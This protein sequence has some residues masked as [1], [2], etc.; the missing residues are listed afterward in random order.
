MKK[1]VFLNWSLLYI[2]LSIFIESLQ[3]SS[4]Y[5]ALA[6]ILNNPFIW[7]F[8]LLLLIFFSSFIFFFKRKKMLFC[9]YSAIWILL[10][11]ASGIKTNFRGDPLMIQDFFL[12]GEATG[13]A[14][15]Y[16]K[17]TDIIFIILLISAS[18]FLV[19]YFWKKERDQIR[20]KNKFSLYILLLYIGLF[21][22]ISKF[23][24]TALY[25]KPILWDIKQSYY[26]YGFP[27]SFIET[28]VAMNPKEPQEYSKE[29]II[30][31]KEEIQR[32]NALN[33]LVP[34][35]K[36]PNI[37]IVQLESFFDPLILNNV[38]F[39]VDPIPYF[40][41]LSKRYSSGVLK[42]SSIG[43]GTSN[44]EFEVLT[45][46]NMDFLSPGSTPYVQ[47]LNTSPVES[48]AHI[49]K[50]YGYSTT[51]LHSYWGN[52]YNRIDVFKNLGFQ[53]FISGEFIPNKVKVGGWYEDKI[54][55]EQIEK[56]LNK[57][58]SLD[59]I[60]TISLQPHGPYPTE[61]INEKGPKVEGP[62][63]ESDKIILENYLY[64]LQQVDEFVK[65][66][67]S[68]I[69]NTKEPSIVVFYGDHL[70]SLGE[71]Y[72]ILDAVSLENSKRYETPYVIWDNIGCKKFDENIEAYML[73]TKVL[74]MINVYGAINSFHNIFKDYDGYMEAFRLLQYDFLYGKNYYFNNIFPH[75]ISDIELGINPLFI[76]SHI[77]QD[78]DIILKGSGFTEHTK[79]FLGKD[80][81]ETTFIDDSTLK[82]SSSSLKDYKEVYAAMVDSKNAILKKSNIY[83]LT[84]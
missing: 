76:S 6:Y 46:L 50:S 84:D 63:S 30:S 7:V 1:V 37:I 29:N 43:G 62:F 68:Y 16:L 13:I 41:S 23:M 33:P 18:M 14:K 34:P 10:S 40:R 83:I 59:F 54:L 69:C 77:T 60:F 39:S 51:A 12:A 58:P 78:E 80:S 53:R 28:I 45:G 26:T 2:I 64:Q 55:T 11:F 27:Y 42:V 48:I 82:V 44:T 20:F 15:E 32:V 3:R 35:T 38:N 65:D 8:N 5:S 47:K 22:F 25:I 74:N 71:N 57:N 9:I 79:I 73:S 31:I 4:L 75:S 17:G 66:L 19:L 61:I 70:P 49:L 52:F 24:I 21:P 36:L 67:V 56:I 72:S 81:I